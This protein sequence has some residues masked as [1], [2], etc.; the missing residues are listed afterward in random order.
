MSSAGLTEHYIGRH[1][2]ASDNIGLRQAVSDYRTTSDNIRLQCDYSGATSGFKDVDEEI[3]RARKH[4]CI[5]DGSSI[6]YA[7]T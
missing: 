6:E 5:M 1:R 3:R 2:T 4:E 7:V